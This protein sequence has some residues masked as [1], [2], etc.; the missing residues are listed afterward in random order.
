MSVNLNV[1]RCQ[2]KGYL[3]VLP[4]LREPR[5]FIMVYGATVDG[6]LILPCLSVGLHVVG[7]GDVV[8]PDV[9]L[10]LEEAEDA[11]EDAPRVDAHAHVQLHVG[12]LHHVAEA[13]RRK[14]GEISSGNGS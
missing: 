1:F 2:K 4:P 5:Q 6:S 12:R 10:P 3:R 8:G 9:V 13:G 14:G 7:G 11:A